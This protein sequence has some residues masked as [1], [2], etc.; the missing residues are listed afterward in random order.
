ML[1]DD[2]DRESPAGDELFVRVIIPLNPN[3]DVTVIDEV[4]L[5][6]PAVRDRNSGFDESSKSGPFTVTNMSVDVIKPVLVLFPVTV[7]K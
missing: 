3:S 4:Q 7:T 5:A 6:S 2:H 1:V